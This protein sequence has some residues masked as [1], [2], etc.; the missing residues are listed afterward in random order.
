[1]SGPCQTSI[2]SPTLFTQPILSG[3]RRWSGDIEEATSPPELQADPGRVIPRYS[4]AGKLAL[5]LSRLSPT[6]SDASLVCAY[7]RC[8]RCRVPPSVLSPN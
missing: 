1:M 2:L 5:L 7:A 8:N 4:S 6:R 3:A